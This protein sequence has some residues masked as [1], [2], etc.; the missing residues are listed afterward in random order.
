MEISKTQATFCV[1]LVLLCLA[2]GLNAGEATEGTRT[3]QLWR[4]L[5]DAPFRVIS[6]HPPPK[7][8]GETLEELGFQSIEAVLSGVERPTDYNSVTFSPDGRFI[9]SGAGDDTVKLWDVETKRLIHSFKGHAASVSSVAFS[10]DGRFITSAAGGY[11]VSRGFIVSGDFTVKL[12]HVETKR[13]IHSFK[14]HTNPVHSVAFSPDGRFI[15][16]GA[17]DATVRLW[18]VEAK[19]LVHT[20]KGH[21]NAVNSVAFS[22]DGRFI[23]SRSRD[24]TVKLWDVE[25]KRLIHTFE[26]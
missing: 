12:W 14:G 19:R 10:F 23:A 21:R 3:Q 6:A 4:V 17:R 26:G 16:S 5:D 20:F 2:M 1:V 24:R 13:L 18:D 25:D 22:P 15:A 11:T 8:G 7:S 9:A